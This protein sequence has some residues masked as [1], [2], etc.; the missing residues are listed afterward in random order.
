MAIRFVK[1]QRYIK[2]K[3][4]LTYDVAS[5]K[6]FFFISFIKDF[7]SFIKDFISCIKQNKII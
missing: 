5:G 4:Y 7:I 6:E 1:I 3:I 2:L